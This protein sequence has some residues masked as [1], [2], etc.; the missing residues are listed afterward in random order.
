MGNFQ[1][2]RGKLGVEVTVDETGRTLV[3][4]KLYGV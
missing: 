4:S 3:I 1:E 2:E